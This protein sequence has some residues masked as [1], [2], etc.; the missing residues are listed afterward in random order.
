MG[1]ESV[2]LRGN[3]KEMGRECRSKQGAV[4]KWEGSL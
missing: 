2:E 4:R 1:G 3:I